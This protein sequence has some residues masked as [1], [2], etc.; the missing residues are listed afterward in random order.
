[1]P[2]S[3]VSIESTLPATNR[4]R[5]ISLLGPKSYVQRSTGTFLA[6]KGCLLPAVLEARLADDVR[7][8]CRYG[9][10]A[11]LQHLLDRVAFDDQFAAA[12]ECVGER[13]V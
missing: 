1:V 4:M 3:N 5:R 12:A 2:C 6:F 8:L 11:I 13:A 7:P 9:L 10:A